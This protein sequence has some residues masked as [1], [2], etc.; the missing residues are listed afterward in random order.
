M[1][2]KNCLSIMKLS[3]K[4][5]VFLLSAAQALVGLTVALIFV[6]TSLVNAQEEPSGTPVVND[7]KIKSLK[8]KLATTVANLRENQ[9]RGFYGE[10]ASA[11]K[12]SFTLVT[13]GNEIKVRF[14]DDALIYSLGTKK[15]EA[16]ADQI[17]NLQKV[18]VVGLFDANEDIHSAQVIWL[19]NLPSYVEGQITAI[20]KEEAAITLKTKNGSTITLDYETATKADEYNPATKKMAKSGLSRLAPGDRLHAWTTPNDEDAQKHDVVRLLRLPAT[21]FE[22][23][24]STSPTPS[25][26]PDEEQ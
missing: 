12:T 11:N 25:A 13:E 17:K 21:M 5:K 9:T 16:K 22:P 19:Q 1:N 14:N 23:T 7:D 24:S 3:K 4:Q 8:E 26:T 10:I 2:R 18:A 15:T 20:D 6:G